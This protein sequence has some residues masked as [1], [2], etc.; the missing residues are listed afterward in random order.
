MIDPIRLGPLVLT[1][2]RLIFVA[3]VLA[4][5]GASALLLRK[6]EAPRYWDMAV[7]VGGL[8]VGRAVFVIA[9]WP[10]FEPRPLSM[11]MVWQG[12]LN[13][14]AT[15]VAGATVAAVFFRRRLRV[16]AR[17]LAAV[18]AAA[19]VWF[20]PNAVAG[21]AGAG[22]DGPLLPS[23]QIRSLDGTEVALQAGGKPVVVNLW[24]TWCPPCRRELP[25]L[26]EIAAAQ[27]EEVAYY[28][29]S[30][31]EEPAVVLDYLEEH[32][33]EGKH[34]YLDTNAGLSQ[35]LEAQ[36]LPTTLFFAADGRFVDGHV[37]EISAARVLEGIAAAREHE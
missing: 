17:P 33:I 5:F 19:L 28:L 24:A 26:T 7:L 22:E 9:N 12:G 25:M 18:A 8:L 36:A 30:Q 23:A 37:G 15:L 27:S 34:I 14:V 31:G 21:G 29:V 11:L 6:K 3:A 2:E 20:V 1:F 10:A 35:V 13:P 32:S 4:F 16:L